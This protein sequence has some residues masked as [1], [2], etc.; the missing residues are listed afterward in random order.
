MKRDIVRYVTECDTCRRVK[1]GHL[2]PAKNLQPL[3]IPEW[4]WED[5]YM[6]FIVGLPRT[7]RGYSIWVTEAE[8]NVKQIH[9]NIL[10]A[11]SRQK[12][13]TDKSRRPLEFEVGDHIYLRFL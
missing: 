1:A 2:R 4:E 5:I 8:E 13:Y 12:R 3:S 6:S 11:Q 9:A 10:T 7:S